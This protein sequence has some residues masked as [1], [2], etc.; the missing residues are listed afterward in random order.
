MRI[1]F[2]SLIALRDV[3]L[4]EVANAGDLDIVRSLD[5][6]CASDGAVG[7]E[8]RPVARLEAPSHLYTFSVANHGV[9]T[10][11]RRTID[12]PVVERVDWWRIQLRFEDAS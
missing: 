6:M 2:T 7:D 9:R 11:L 10:R 12:A 8:S 3:D 4:R 1:E 5:E